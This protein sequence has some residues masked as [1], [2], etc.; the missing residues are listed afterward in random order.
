MKG[1]VFTEFLDLVEDKFGYEVVDQLLSETE[2]ESDGAYTAIGTYDYQELIGMVVGLSQKTG[3]EVPV[4]VHTFGRHLFQRFAQRYESVASKYTSTFELLQSLEDCIH[5][6]VLKLY[7]R[8]ELP[9]I[10]HEQPD[11]NT[12][13]LEYRSNRP[14]AELCHGLIEQCAEH[15]GEDIEISRQDLNEDGTAARFKLVKNQTQ[16]NAV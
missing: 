11:S 1:V 8:A 16:P 3:L 12:L 10:A 6:E 4:L 14:F 7:P 2:T 5:V 9:S 15:F 13:E